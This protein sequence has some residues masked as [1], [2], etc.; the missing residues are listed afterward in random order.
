MYRLRI[1]YILSILLAFMKV[2][3]QENE[4]FE[5]FNARRQERFDMFKEQKRQEFE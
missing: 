4:S 2:K 3:A 1:I 5:Q